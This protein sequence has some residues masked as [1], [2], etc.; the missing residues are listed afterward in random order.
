MCTYHLQPSAPS[1]LTS[2]DLGTW[3]HGMRLLCVCLLCILTVF[4]RSGQ[5]L[6]IVHVCPGWVLN[7]PDSRNDIKRSS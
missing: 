2:S 5:N 4:D 6:N 1:I 7:Y 3:N